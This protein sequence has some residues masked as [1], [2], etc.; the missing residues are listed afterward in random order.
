M[1]EKGFWRRLTEL[2]CTS[3]RL[4]FPMPLVHLDHLCSMF[5]SSIQDVQQCNISSPMERSPIWD[6][7]PCETFTVLWYLFCWKLQ[8]ILNHHFFTI[9]SLSHHRL[10]CS[11]HFWADFLVDAVGEKRSLMD[12]RRVS[13]YNPSPVHDTYTWSW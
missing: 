8:V 7:H 3:S 6:V 4:L 9:P 10:F 2:I 13:P 5:T 1:V 11:F 12:P